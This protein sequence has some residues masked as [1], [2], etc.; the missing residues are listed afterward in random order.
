MSRENVEI[1]RRGFEH[2]MATGEFLAENTHPDFGGG[3]SPTEDG[4]AQGVASI[5]RTV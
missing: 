3:C 2:F 4:I 1:V 5:T